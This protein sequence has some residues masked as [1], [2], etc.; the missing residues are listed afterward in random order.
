MVMS[1]MAHGKLLR[2]PHP[3]A[4]IKRIDTTRARA[5]PGVRVAEGG[6][7]LPVRISHAA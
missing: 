1:R 7:A 4:L 2:S 5:L 3:H 6:F